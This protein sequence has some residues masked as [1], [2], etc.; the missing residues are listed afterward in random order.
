[1]PGTSSMTSRGKEGRHMS[2]LNGDLDDFGLVL[3]SHL[4]FILW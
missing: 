1:M 3:V 4:L 2:I